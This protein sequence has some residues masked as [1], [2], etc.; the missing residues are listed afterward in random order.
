[1]PSDIGIFNT[2]IHRYLGVAKKNGEDRGPVWGGKRITTCL[3][4]DPKSLVEKKAYSSLPTISTGNENVNTLFSK[5][6]KSSDLFKIELFGTG[7]VF[8]LFGVCF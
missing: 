5:K 4:E 1:V 8:F 7:V 6:Q 3:A 2:Q